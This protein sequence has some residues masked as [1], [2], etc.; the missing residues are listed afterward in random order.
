M[1]LPAAIATEACRIA[2]KSPWIPLA[3]VTV[4][5]ATYRYAANTEPVS[6]G[7][8]SW[9]P[10]AIRFTPPDESQQGELPVAT[11]AISNVDRI[12]GL[13][14]SSA[15]LSGA[16]ATMILLCTAAPTAD[17]SPLTRTHDIVGVSITEQWVSLRL[18]APFLI[19]H[20]FPARRYLGNYCAWVARYTGAEC[21]YS[22]ALPTCSGTLDDCRDHGNSHRFG[23]FPG[24]TNPGFRVV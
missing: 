14:V 18:A 12:L 15:G 19:R 22:G 9:A 6:H 8:H 2:T 17:H 1:G 10:T 21:G 23:G 24:L 20:P 5:G 3:A 7:G 11:L 16:T 4:G 13:A